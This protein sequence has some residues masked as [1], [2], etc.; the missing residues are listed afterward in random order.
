ML[1]RV[2]CWTGLILALVAI[3][4]NVSGLGAWLAA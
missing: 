1:E 2:L 3:Y 4:V